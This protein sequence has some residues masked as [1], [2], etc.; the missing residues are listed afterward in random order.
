M[1]RNLLLAAAIM[2]FLFP[3]KAQI[4]KGSLFLGGQVG[5]STQTYSFENTT[6]KSNHL[7]LSVSPAIGKAIR[8]NLILG[9][10]LYFSYYRNASNKVIYEQGHS[11]GAGI[12]LR[13]YL[14][15][16]KSFYLFGNNALG[17]YFNSSNFNSSYA[18]YTPYNY[19][20]EGYTIYF[21]FSPGLAYALTNK[22][23]VEV[24]FN[25][26][27]YAR[28]SYSRQVVI[29]PQSGV[30]SNS[31]V[32]GFEAGASLNSLSSLLI[33]FRVLLAK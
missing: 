27:A 6:D 30:S 21:S 20:P 4:R 13:R 15:L 28:Y 1:K 22:L 26:L 23:H 7:F 9:G 32:G 14:L 18:P 19:T 3:A 25:D 33:G 12:F 5:L 17:A 11:E 2:A 8:E 16:G 29:Q 24:A 31:T 10:S